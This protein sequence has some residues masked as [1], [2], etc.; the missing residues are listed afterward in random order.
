MGYVAH[1]TRLAQLYMQISDK[2]E[3]IRDYLSVANGGTWNTFLETTLKARITKR[4]G[5]LCKSN[6]NTNMKQPKSRF[7]GMFEDFTNRNKNDNIVD[8][9]NDEEDEESA[10]MSGS[11]FHRAD[12]YGG[13]FKDQR[14]KQSEM[15]DLMKMSLDYDDDD[16]NENENKE[17]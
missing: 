6:T 2:N 4:T 8:D 14:T 7:M 9:E 10:L 17:D 15:D 13:G 1:L 12:D 5:S 11:M 3:T 16:E